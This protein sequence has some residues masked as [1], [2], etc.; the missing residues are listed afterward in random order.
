M[1]AEGANLEQY[2]FCILVVTG[3]LSQGQ[4]RLCQGLHRPDPK[5]GVPMM[6]GARQTPEIWAPT[7]PRLRTPLGQALPTCRARAYELIGQG[8]TVILTL[9]TVNLGL[10][11]P[12]VACLRSARLLVGLSSLRAAQSS[13]QGR[14]GFCCRL[15]P[16]GQTLPPHA[17]GCGF[18]SQ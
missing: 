15:C 5:I 4:T 10:S 14:A 17:L 6:L 18:P 11:F 13:Q 3:V 8:R 9:L 1:G 2:I 16:R 12:Q 7:G